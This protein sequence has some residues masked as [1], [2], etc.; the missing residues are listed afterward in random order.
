MMKEELLATLI[1]F[2]LIQSNKIFVASIFF[3]IIL[4][5]RSAN[6]LFF[7]YLSIAMIDI[8]FSAGAAASRVVPG[9]SVAAGTW[10]YM[11][12]RKHVSP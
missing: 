4:G 8:R 3:F 9:M 12:L 7:D 11:R 5:A 6:F 10:F 2:P 1:S